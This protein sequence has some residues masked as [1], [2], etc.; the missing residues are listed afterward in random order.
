M[1]AGR[2]ATM[3]QPAPVRAGHRLELEIARTATAVFA[4]KGVE[5]TSLTDIADA[6]GIPTSLLWDRFAAK[7]DC[8]VPLFSYATERIARRMDS[9]S[10][11]RPLIDAFDAYET[12]GTEG[13]DGGNWLVPAGSDGA[14]RLD[15]ALDALRLARDEPVVHAV[16]LRESFAALP[17]VASAIAARAGRS[18]PDLDATVQAGMLLSALQLALREYAWTP[19]EAR[20]ADLPD[21]LLEAVRIAM[22]GLPA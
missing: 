21:T 16:W 11:D 9:W 1:N 8:L 3:Q 2:T 20:H 13:G 19:P 18:R 14:E 15:A 4:A 22:R 10:M 12:F 17:L 5:R 7:E 6:A